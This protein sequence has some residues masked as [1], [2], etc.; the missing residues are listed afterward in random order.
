MA[1]HVEVVSTDLRRV[2]VRVTPGTYM[3]DVLSEACQKL[4]FKSDNYLLK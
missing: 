4:N 1:A 2:K 3:I